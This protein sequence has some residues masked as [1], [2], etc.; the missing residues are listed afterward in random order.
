MRFYQ[1][2]AFTENPYEG[3]PCAVFPAAEGLSERQMLA[4]AGEMNL[5]ETA[6]L[7]R[8]EKADMKARYFT[9]TEEIPLAGHPT[10]ASLFV[11]LH[12]GTVEL[13]EHSAPLEIAME[14]T[15]GTVTV[16]ARRR[17]GRVWITMQQLPPRFGRI[18]S[19]GEVSPAFGLSPSDF[20]PDAPVQTVSTGTP[21]LM[22]PLKDEAALRKARLVSGEYRALK[23]RGDFSS[24]HLFVT[25][26][27]GDNVSTSARHFGGATESAED[28]FTGSATGGMG[29]YLYKYKL[30]PGVEFTA[31][32][33]ASVRRPGIA[34]CTVL[35]DDSYP[36][37][38]AGVEV[39]GTAVVVFSGELIAIPEIGE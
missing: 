20:L 24:P 3:N 23:A 30:M 39:T 35:P 37:G 21:Q 17:G 28:P 9:P 15:A 1:V 26:T 19:P 38:L 7:F 32:Q 33:G 25:Y 4:I 6:F 11:M 12:E 16:R 34:A 8:S 10:I 2:D 36:E 5:S 22:V 18:Y 27:G 31:L 29:A 13:P 14:L